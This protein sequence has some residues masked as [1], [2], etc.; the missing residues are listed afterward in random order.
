[1]TDN[2]R[3][4]CLLSVV[5]KGDVSILNQRLLQ[6]CERMKKFGEEQGGFRPNRSTA[7]IMFSC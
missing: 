3:A 2:Y 6:W 7:D 1:M 5:G 4:I